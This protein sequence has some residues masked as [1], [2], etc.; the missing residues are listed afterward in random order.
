MSRK[1]GG[2][3]VLNHK[4]D[5]ADWIPCFGHCQLQGADMN[6][7]KAAMVMNY[8]ATLTDLFDDFEEKGKLN[9]KSKSYKT[10]MR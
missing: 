2:L 10:D 4:N 3:Q 1:Y 5:L 8:T 9:T 6:L 7:N